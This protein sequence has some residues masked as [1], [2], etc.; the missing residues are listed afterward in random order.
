LYADINVSEDHAASSLR[1]GAH[2][3]DIQA[4]KL[5]TLIHGKGRGYSLVRINRRGDQKRSHFGMTVMIFV[6]G[7]KQNSEKTQPFSCACERSVSPPLFPLAP[8]GCHL[9]TPP[10]VTVTAFLATCH[11]PIRRS[12][13]FNPEEGG[14]M[15]FRNDAILLQDYTEN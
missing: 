2:T 15:H 5:I 4:S 10:A 13:H 1:V 8:I 9:L 3:E 14:R 11:K 12:M 7:G 6:T